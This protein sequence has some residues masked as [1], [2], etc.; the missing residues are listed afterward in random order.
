M[1]DIQIN[2]KLAI[3]DA[4][5]H[6]HSSRSSGPGGQNVN[7][8]NTRITLV[9]DLP[10]CPTLTDE[11]RRRLRR[12][13]ASRIDKDGRLHITA[14]RFRSQHANRQDALDRLATLM[15]DALKPT[16]HRR[17][18]AIPKKAIQK[19]L[20]LKKRR[21]ITKRLRGTVDRD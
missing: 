1:T 5:L 13:L 18:T 14:Q 8:L 15:A 9:V 6:F 2:D 4:C 11:Q 3:P 21:S 7:K 16:V 20:E 17:K 10:N 19:R 12:K